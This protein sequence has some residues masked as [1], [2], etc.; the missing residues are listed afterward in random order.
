L[1]CACV[2]MFF[3]LTFT[4]LHCQSGAGCLLVCLS[5]VCND[6]RTAANRCEI[7][8]SLLSN[9]NGNAAPHFQIPF[10]GHHWMWK[11]SV[12]STMRDDPISNAAL[13]T[14]FKFVDLDL[15]KNMPMDLAKWFGHQAHLIFLLFYYDD[16]VL[17]VCPKCYIN[18][19]FGDLLLF[20]NPP[21]KQFSSTRN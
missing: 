6:M 13:R 15:F 20:S 2:Q 9:T 18:H 17:H 16:F 4:M 8:Q 19:R 5:V 7:D 12:M 14:Y 1:A 10:E 21:L 3:T 11:L